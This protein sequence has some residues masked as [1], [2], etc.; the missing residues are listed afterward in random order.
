MVREAAELG[1]KS[2]YFGDDDST[3]LGFNAKIMSPNNEMLVDTNGIY[4]LERWN[5]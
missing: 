1:H 4:R 3:C 5:D 2:A